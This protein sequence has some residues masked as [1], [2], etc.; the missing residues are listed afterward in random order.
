MCVC[1]CVPS[2]VCVCVQEGQCFAPMAPMA[3]MGCAW[4]AD[5]CGATVMPC[6]RAATRFNGGQGQ[7]V[8]QR[9]VK[10]KATAS[11]IVFQNIFNGHLNPDKVKQCT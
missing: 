5:V 2:Y 4:L 1:V 9:G 10:T 3:R 8:S 11:P 7:H 6:Q